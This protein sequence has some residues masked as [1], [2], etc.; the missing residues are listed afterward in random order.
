MDIIHLFNKYFFILMIIQGFFLTFIDPK[1]FKKDN[2][3]K[4]VLKSK[5]IGIFFF[6]FSILL[7]ALSIY[8]F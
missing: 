7:Y 5:I 1:N 4:T 6:I 2:L 3:K 8:S